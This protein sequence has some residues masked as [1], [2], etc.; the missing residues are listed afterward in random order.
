[1]ATFKRGKNWWTDFSVN[2]QRF[3]QSLD[4][5]DW[6]EALQNEKDLIARAKEGKLSIA[7]QSFARL[8]FPEALDRYLLD[9]SAHV[10]PRSHRTETDH[11]KPLRT[12]FATVPVGRIS[13]DAILAYIRERKGEGI[14]N[15]TINMEIGILRRVLKRAK[16]WSLIADEIPRLPERRDVGRAMSFEEKT[17]LLHIAAARPEWETARLAAILALNTTMRGCELKGLCWRDVDFIERTLT[18][19]RSKTAAG[20]RVIP[21]NT[22]AW[23]VVLQLRDKS[24]KLFG[25]SL[26]ADWHLFPHAEGYTKPD[27]TRPMSGWRTAWRR[28]TRAVQCPSCGGLQDPAPNC[29]KKKCKADMSKLKSPLHGLRFHD[30]RHHAITELA[31]SQASERTIMSIAGHISP[32]MLDHYSHVRLH[33]KRQALDGL[34]T[35]KSEGA[36]NNGDSGKGYGTNHVTKTQPEGMPLS[37]VLEKNGGD[38]ETRTR[39]LCRDRA[40]F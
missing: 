5:T 40:A 31:E 17:R 33:A 8:A 11:A 12:Y 32:K 16:R 6:R 9:R 18:I 1:M 25:D 23:S 15:V 22:D 19:R 29:R 27:P 28:L 36:A 35:K 14:S 26:D 39:D 21:L 10:A 24:R 13:A 20:E 4:T 34:A 38:D 37:Q 7:G 2:G 30:L 3:R